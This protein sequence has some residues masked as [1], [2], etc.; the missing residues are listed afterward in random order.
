MATHFQSIVRAT[1]SN[2]EKTAAML[3]A[4]SCNT[5]SSSKWF[6]VITIVMPLITQMVNRHISMCR[7]A[8]FF[9]SVSG[10]SLLLQF[11]TEVYLILIHR[12]KAPDDIK[13]Y[14]SLTSL[15]GNN[16]LIQRRYDRR[17][18]L[19][20]LEATQCSWNKDALHLAV[21]LYLLR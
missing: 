9:I 12:D 11:H 17:V 14:L 19:K 18:I 2:T 20:N 6:F 5:L 21:K 4:L 15:I 13:V 8:C 7:L 10:I 1:N 3:Q 16:S